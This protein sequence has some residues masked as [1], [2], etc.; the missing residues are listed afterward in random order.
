MNNTSYISVE[1]SKNQPVNRTSPVYV[2]EKGSLSLNDII[3]EKPADFNGQIDISWLTN[4]LNQKASEIKYAP[5]DALYMP[6]GLWVSSAYGNNTIIAV[7]A[8]GKICLS[9]DYGSNWEEKQINDNLTAA[10]Y[11]NEIFILLSNTGKTFKSTDNGASWE[12]SIIADD[13]FSC[14]TY[15]HN[16]FIAGTVSGRIFISENY[17]KS[18]Q[19]VCEYENMQIS[20]ILYSSSNII[21]AVGISGSPLS[22]YS[23]DGGLSWNEIDMPSSSWIS[24]TYGKERFTACAYEG[25]TRLIYCNEKDIL[26][27]TPVWQKISLSYNE[28]WKDICYGANVYTLASSTG[29]T[30][31]SSDGIRWIKTPCP[32]GLWNNILRTDY[33]FMIFSEAAEENNLNAIR[34][35]NGGLAGIMFATLNEIIQGENT[36]KAVNPQTLKDYLAYRTG[37]NSSQYP[38]YSDDLLIECTSLDTRQIKITNIGSESL[39]D[40]YNSIKTAGI[41]IIEKHLNNGSGLETGYMLVQEENNKIHQFISPDYLF[42]TGYMR[43]FSSDTWSSWQKKMIK[44]EDIENLDLSNNNVIVSS[45]SSYSDITNIIVEENGSIKKIS[46]EE[47]N[48][49]INNKI[50]D[51]LELM[52]GNNVYWNSTAEYKTGAFVLGSDN[53]L[54]YC[55]AANGSAS[56]QNP[57]SASAYWLKII[58]SNGKINADN[59][60]VSLGA[61][62]LLNNIALTNNAITGI[63]PI[64]KGGTGTLD[65]FGWKQVYSADEF[66]TKIG[67]K[68]PFTTQQLVNAVVKKNT[69]LFCVVNGWAKSSTQ[70]TDFPGSNLSHRTIINYTDANQFYLETVDPFNLTTYICSVNGGKVDAWKLCRNSDASIPVTI[71]GTG[72]THGALGK[73]GTVKKL[74]PT[75]SNG[76]NYK[77]GDMIYRYSISSNSVNQYVPAGGT[78]I[79]QSIVFSGDGQ[80]ALVEYGNINIYPGGAQ[81]DTNPD[82]NFIHILTKIS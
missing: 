51:A 43:Y 16:K 56:P 63:L 30:L 80:Q 32:Y 64:S 62:A 20:K 6:Q 82:V 19:K 50:T 22:I 73:A 8:D 12:E 55:K 27:K 79:V 15:N 41:Y 71:G 11:G 1:V 24:L 69:P 10:A 35:S 70:V 3:S 58:N 33:F 5:W 28:P 72:L 74:E 65:A 76:T 44:Q 29:V 9:Y 21:M 38:V 23:I 77:S 37:K 49:E 66:N 46:K 61:L 47:V 78:W 59:L 7:S 39:I 17:G 4:A 75:A 45:D 60:S 48:E 18:W 81:L 36:D 13:N 26:N 52:A 67:L 57:V 40:D 2:Q 31:A 68:Y 25:E 42:N 14:I 53:A 34:S 54:Y